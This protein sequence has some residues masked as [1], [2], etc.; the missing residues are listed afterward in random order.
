MSLTFY[1]LKGSSHVYHPFNWFH[2]AIK[3]GCPDNL[4]CR[5]AHTSY[6][7]D[8]PTSVYELQEGTA[9]H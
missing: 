3:I 9:M 1:A 8:N 6:P 7:V 4:C 2:P 5:Q